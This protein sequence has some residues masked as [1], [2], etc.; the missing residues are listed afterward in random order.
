MGG[1]KKKKN[2]YFEELK[3]IESL[4]TNFHFV[5]DKIKDLITKSIELDKMAIKCERK[6]SELRTMSEKFHKKSI[7]IALEFGFNPA[8]DKTTS[9]NS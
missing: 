4:T 8:E 9:E 2:C 7:K 3:K 5:D 6:A 1:K